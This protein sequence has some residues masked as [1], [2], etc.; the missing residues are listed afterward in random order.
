MK[1][2]YITYYSQ[3]VQRLKS[4]RTRE[5]ADNLLAHNGDCTGVR[6]DDP[7]YVVCADCPLRVH[8]LRDGV[9]CLRVLDTNTIALLRK[10]RTREDICN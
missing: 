9:M 1:L 8:T 4:D 10:M 7:K 6:P 5:M 2:L 3:V